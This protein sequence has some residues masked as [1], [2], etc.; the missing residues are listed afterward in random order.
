MTTGDKLLGRT[1]ALAPNSYIGS[2]SLRIGSTTGFSFLNLDD[3]VA[4][5]QLTEGTLRV[6]VKR[7]EQNET[8]EIDTPNLAFSVLR[9]GTYRIDVVTRTAIPP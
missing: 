7:L 2:A 9:P 3:S 4:Q 8:F 1:T 5:I 6:R